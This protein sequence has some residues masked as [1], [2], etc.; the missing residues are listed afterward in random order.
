M[1]FPVLIG[2]QTQRRSTSAQALS[3]GKCLSSRPLSHHFLVLPPLPE[4]LTGLLV[5]LFL[6]LVALLSFGAITALQ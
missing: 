4:P 1:M 3:A 6:I 5:D 2:S